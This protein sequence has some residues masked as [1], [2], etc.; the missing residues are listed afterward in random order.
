MLREKN[1]G[2][3]EE[4]A[5]KLARPSPRFLF[6]LREFFLEKKKKKKKRKKRK[7]YG[8]IFFFKNV[9]IFF[10]GKVLGL[11]GDLTLGDALLFH[12]KSWWIFRN[13][14]LEYRSIF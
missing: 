9:T 7:V 5:I 1:G 14:S 3:L 12:T 4:S 6:G 10:W 2:A 11:P 8:C 13:P